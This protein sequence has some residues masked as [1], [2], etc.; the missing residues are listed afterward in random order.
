MSIVTL[1]PK[2]QVVV[3]K[4]VREQ[5]KWKPG[6]RLAVL[7]KGETACYVPVPSI[8]S[9]RGFAPGINLSDIREEVDRS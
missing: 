6:Q 8:R 5:L 9:L 7:A 1:S 3:P 2:N 4:S